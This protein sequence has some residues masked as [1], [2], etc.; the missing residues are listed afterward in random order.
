M[1]TATWPSSV[2]QQAT[3]HSPEPCLQL[4]LSHVKYP[5]RTVIRVL[6]SDSSTSP[7]P[8]SP[9][10]NSREDRP[11]DPTTVLAVQQVPVPDPPA[12]SINST[13][14]PGPYLKALELQS[15]LPDEFTRHPEPQE[16]VGEQIVPQL[17]NVAIRG[18]GA[19]WEPPDPLVKMFYQ[20]PWER[21]TTDLR[22]ALAGKFYIP[23]VPAKDRL[24]LRSLIDGD[25]IQT[26]NEKFF[27]KRR[28]EVRCDLDPSPRLLVDIIPVASDD[29]GTAGQPDT[30]T[31]QSD[32]SE[33]GL[34]SMPGSRPEEGSASRRNRSVRFD[35]SSEVHDDSTREV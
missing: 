22:D 14:T 24:V 8:E 21:F 16:P 15:W 20:Q 35:Q 11:Q 25:L 31:T 32:N 5:R 28:I 17:H 7:R 26:W 33:S 4:T 10:R 34:P 30:S 18:I 6:D 23:G 13:N 9:R 1:V 3:P 29:F 2:Q 12:Y 27:R 19:P